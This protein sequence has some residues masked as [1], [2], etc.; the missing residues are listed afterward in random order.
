MHYYDKKLPFIV[1]VIIFSFSVAVCDRRLPYPPP[2]APKTPLLTVYL[3]WR[4]KN[5][6]PPAC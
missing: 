3:F 6:Y 2:P 5:Y 4:K 1:V